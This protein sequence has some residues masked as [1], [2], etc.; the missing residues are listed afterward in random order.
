MY[1]AEAFIRKPAG[2][3]DVRNTTGTELSQVLQ[4]STLALLKSFTPRTLPA[5]A[6]SAFPTVRM[7]LLGLIYFDC[8]LSMRVRVDCQ[9]HDPHPVDL[10]TI[11]LSETQW[12]GCRSAN[13]K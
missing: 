1:L 8:Y 13:C 9:C 10:V 4:I 3:G 2:T 12:G 11:F 7:C 5:S 6:F